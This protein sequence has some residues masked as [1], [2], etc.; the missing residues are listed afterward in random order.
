MEEEEESIVSAEESFKDGVTASFPARDVFSSD[1]FFDS[2][3]GRAEAAGA[4]TAPLSGFVTD[5]SPGAGQGQGQGQH[6]PLSDARQNKSRLY[7]A[8]KTMA[9][10]L[11]AALKR[12]KNRPFDEPGIFGGKELLQRAGDM[13]SVAQVGLVNKYLVAGSAR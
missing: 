7:Q 10:R 12:S 4:A 5:K 1:S 11:K 6:F 3:A 13:H 2:W 9:A 8:Q